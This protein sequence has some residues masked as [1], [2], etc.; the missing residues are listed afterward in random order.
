MDGWAVVCLT[1]EMVK[2]KNS[3]HVDGMDDELG[4]LAVMFF[5]IFSFFLVTSDLGSEI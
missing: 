3:R 5:S 4:L 2:G 1:C